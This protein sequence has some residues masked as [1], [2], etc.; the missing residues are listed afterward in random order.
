MMSLHRD[1]LVLATHG[2]VNIVRHSTPGKKYSM[3]M[4]HRM[5]SL[6]YAVVLVVLWRAPGHS[7]HDELPNRTWEAVSR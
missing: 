2:Q 7:C 1:A 4:Y 5:R 6:S 3:S